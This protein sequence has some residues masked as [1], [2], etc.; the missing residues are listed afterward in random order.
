M[1]R[2]QWRTQDKMIQFSAYV[3]PQRQEQMMRTRVHA[4]KQVRFVSVEA[5]RSDHPSRDNVMFG[6]GGSPVGGGGPARQ[7][8]GH[9]HDSTGRPDFVA[10]GL[11]T[12]NCTLRGKR[13]H[14]FATQTEHEMET[15]GEAVATSTKP[16]MQSVQHN[17]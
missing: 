15:C 4:S 16:T 9:V 7:Q 6:G 13:F 1:N 8:Q 10:L 11:N 17:L 3:K 5:E 14:T 2:D 12:S